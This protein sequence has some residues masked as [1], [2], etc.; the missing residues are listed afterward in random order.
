MIR[1]PVIALYKH[2]LFLFSLSR[3]PLSAM[4]GVGVLFGFWNFGLRLDKNFSLCQIFQNYDVIIC[5]GEKQKPLMTANE[6]EHFR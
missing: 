5:F 3:L 2:L 1:T 6:T 4:S